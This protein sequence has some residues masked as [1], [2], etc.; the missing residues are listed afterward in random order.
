MLVPIF[1]GR[2]NVTGKVRP[3]V[4]K[5]CVP[6]KRGDIVDVLEPDP[7]HGWHYVR[8]GD[9]RCGFAPSR[10]IVPMPADEKPGGQS[11]RASAGAGAN[12]VPSS[13]ASGVGTV[14]TQ[15]AH[16]PTPATL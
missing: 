1:R 2:C 9:G 6:L 11:N 13:G 7:G 5:M 15:H 8:L 16:A 4:I 12:A 14:D 3:E 10:V